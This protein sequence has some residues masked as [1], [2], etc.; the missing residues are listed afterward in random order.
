MATTTNSVTAATPVAAV[1]PGG[2][3]GK[4]TTTATQ[5]ASG[6]GDAAADRFLTLLVAQLRN[7]DPLNPLDNAQV[8]TQLAQLSTVSGINK[9]NDSFGKLAASLGAS[10]YLQATALVGHDVILAGGGTLAVA[11][12]KGS[13]GFGLAGA[14]TQATVTI[15]DTAGKAVRTISLGAQPAGVST[16]VWDGK[17]DAGAQVAD[18]TYSFSV[19]ATAGGQAVAVEPYTVGRVM[20]IVPGSDGTKLRLAGLGLVDLAQILQIN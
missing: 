18:G 8:T 19:S 17:N 6:S 13:Y 9:L 2:A 20:G 4:A 15:T 1:T 7:Q 16:L 14:A 3:A 10:Q 5:G 11:S 12:G